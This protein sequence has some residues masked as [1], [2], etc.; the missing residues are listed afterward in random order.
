MQ[1]AFLDHMW[2]ISMTNILETMGSKAIQDMPRTP[3]IA[4]LLNEGKFSH[5]S[6][7]YSF[8]HVFLAEIAGILDT[9]KGQIQEMLIYLYTDRT[10]QI[11]SGTE[12]AMS[13]SSKV[14]TNIIYHGF[15]LNRFSTDLSGIR[16]PATLHAAIRWDGNRK[17]KNND[18]PD[19][20]HATTAL[21]YFDTFLTEHSLRGLITRKDLALDHLYG[22]TVVSDPISAVEV[23]EKA[24]CN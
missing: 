24:I 7:H 11:P 17:F 14:L 19:I 2:G 13:D 16:I 6:E 4:K 3:D 8:R 23:I 12:V 10:E 15:R 21:P 20:G 22:C 9:L 5:S 18:M 1:K